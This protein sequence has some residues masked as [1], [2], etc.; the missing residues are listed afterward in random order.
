MSFMNASAKVAAAARSV[1]KGYSWGDR[2]KAVPSMVKAVLFHGWRSDNV[3]RGTII[4]SLLGFMYAV[5]PLDFIPELFLGPFG[6][7]D[8]IAIATVSLVFLV[9]GADAWLESEMATPSDVIQ[10][11]VVNNETV[12]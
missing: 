8:D 5:S 9:K 10:G 4:L 3:H 11:I 12:N 2:F 6:L 1:P 7:T